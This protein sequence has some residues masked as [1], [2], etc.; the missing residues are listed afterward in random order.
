VAGVEAT[1]AV[2]P[3]G[4]QAGGIALRVPTPVGPKPLFPGQVVDDVLFD[5]PPNDFHGPD[6][7]EPAR[8]GRDVPHVRR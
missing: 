3:P 4:S 7:E 1:A 8:L 6:R 2:E 5:D